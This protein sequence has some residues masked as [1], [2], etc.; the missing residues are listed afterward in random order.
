MKCWSIGAGLSFVVVSGCGA[1]DRGVT[2]GEFLALVKQE[3]DTGMYIVDG[4]EPVNSLEE[5]RSYYDRW[6]SPGA[7]FD[8]GTVAQPL[9]VNRINGA[10]D[11]WSASAAR[12]IT[13]CASSSSFGS[14]YAAVVNAMEAASSAWEAVAAVNFIHSTSQDGSCTRAN[15]IVVF[16]LRQVSGQPYLARSF[17]PSSSRQ[18]RELLIDA[19]SFGNITPYTL[20][21]ILRHELGHTLGFRHEHTRPEAGGVCFEDNSWRALTTYDSASVMHYPQCNGTQRGDLV[22]TPRDQQGAAALYGTSLPP[23]GG[24]P[25]DAG[26]SEVGP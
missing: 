2:W 12:S 20:T 23:D 13:F 21:G 25:G 18:S 15:N 24:P 10:D 19:S 7:P 26:V 3:P 8:F 5:L 6:V 22:L 9:I 14:R 4:D 1:D 16:N 17:F 11:R